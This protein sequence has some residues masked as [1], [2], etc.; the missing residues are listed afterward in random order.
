MAAISLKL[1]VLRTF[2]KTWRMIGSGPSHSAN[3]PDS[4]IMFTSGSC[5][6]RSDGG[7]SSLNPLLNS[8][9][10]LK[11]LLKI[12]V[13]VFKDNYSNCSLYL[14]KENSPAD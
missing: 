9:A 4:C 8:S 12:S 3:V 14:M 6:N 5:K 7:M 13:N 11:R 10:N 2:V 1:D